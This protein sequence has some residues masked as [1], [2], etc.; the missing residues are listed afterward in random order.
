M[1]TSILRRSIFGQ[2]DFSKTLRC[3]NCSHKINSVFDMPGFLGYPRMKDICNSIIFEE[4]PTFKFI[5]NITL[6][7][8]SKYLVIFFLF[9]IIDIIL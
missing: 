4:V 3:L 5:T 2:F 6:P 7:H 1:T 8:D 9:W